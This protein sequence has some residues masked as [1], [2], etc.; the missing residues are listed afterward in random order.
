MDFLQDE[1]G[2][3]RIWQW[4][5]IIAA[6]ILLSWLAQK[7][8][9]G[10]GG[11]GSGRPVDR[12]QGDPHAGTQPTGGIA[13][14]GSGGG[15]GGFSD[16]PPEPEFE[17]VEERPTNR[18]WLAVALQ[19]VSATGQWEPAE[20]DTALRNYLSGRTL[21]DEQFKIVNRALHFE[22]APPEGAPPID[23]ERDEVER[24]PGPT[25]D[26][27]GGGSGGGGGGDTADDEATWRQRVRDYYAQGHASPGQY[28]GSQTGTQV[29]NRLARQ[30]ANGDRSWPDVKHSIDLQHTAASQGLTEAEFN[31]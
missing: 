17:V 30:L 26:G 21:T 19:S 18:Q 28:H 8:I 27:D 13:V 24:D 29:V 10:S 9:L 20:V 23:R 22:G 6:A 3:F 12:T 25:D 14:D 7:Y 31:S 4:L 15:G 2:P 16:P 5:A 11:G 1:L